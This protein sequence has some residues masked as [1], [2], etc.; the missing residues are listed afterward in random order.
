MSEKNLCQKNFAS[1]KVL[2]AKYFEIQKNVGGG[3]CD[4]DGVNR[5]GAEDTKAGDGVKTKEVA[6]D[7]DEEEEKLLEIVII[8]IVFIRYK[9]NN[10]RAREV[11][12]IQEHVLSA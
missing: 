9:I 2:G 1:N 3:E 4:L 12:L 8:F 7:D 6:A 10:V 11:F 5:E